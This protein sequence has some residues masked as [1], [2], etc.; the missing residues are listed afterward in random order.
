MESWPIDTL[1]Q[2]F[3]E[4]GAR[5]LLN[6]LEYMKDSSLNLSTLT[7]MRQFFELAFDGSLCLPIDLARMRSLLVVGDSGIG[8]AIEIIESLLSV[9]PINLACALKGKSASIMI[10]AKH[11]N[12][13]VRALQLTA[14][15]EYN[16]NFQNR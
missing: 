2:C 5:Y 12:L 16:V 9:S 15:R 1:A 13:N 4:A 6:L 10:A 14:P 8:I 7:R 11:H 3:G